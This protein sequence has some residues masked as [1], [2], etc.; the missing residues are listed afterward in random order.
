M[1]KKVRSPAEIKVPAINK[2][3][4][5][6]IRKKVLRFCDIKRQYLLEGQSEET[7]TECAGRCCSVLRGEI[8]CAFGWQYSVW[9]GNPV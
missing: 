2:T 1:N 3:V 5:D 8:T 6:F 4:T 9:E 7:I